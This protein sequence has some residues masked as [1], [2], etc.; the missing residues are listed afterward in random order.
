MKR[1][2]SSTAEMR[3]L[4]SGRSGAYCALTS[5][6]GIVGTAGHFSGVPA[7]YEVADGE[8]EEPENRVVDE[9]EAVVEVVP[10][11][12]DGPADAGQHEA[13]D[14]RADEGQD[15]VAAEGH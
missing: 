15:G 8:D 12:P 14:R 4:S 11:A 10:V 3:S 6:S 5:I 9:A 7:E 2:S 1:P 13:P